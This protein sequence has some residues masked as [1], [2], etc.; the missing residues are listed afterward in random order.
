MD[1]FSTIKKIRIKKNDAYLNDNNNKTIMR[2]VFQIP[3]NFPFSLTDGI[4]LDPMSWIHF[5]L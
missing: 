2:F 3:T 5:P 1:P 4:F